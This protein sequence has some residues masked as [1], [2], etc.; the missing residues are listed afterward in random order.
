MWQALEGKTWAA[1][2]VQGM[3]LGYLSP[4]AA[5]KRTLTHWAVQRFHIGS[6][7]DIGRQ[8]RAASTWNMAGP[9]NTVET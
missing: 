2:A 6:S 8:P 5:D 4:Y 9:R 1:N 3:S 7:A